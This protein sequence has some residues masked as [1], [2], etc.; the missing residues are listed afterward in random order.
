MNTSPTKFDAIGKIYFMFLIL[1]QTG[2]SL[3]AVELG[4]KQW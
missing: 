2:D 3:S 4:N 1:L